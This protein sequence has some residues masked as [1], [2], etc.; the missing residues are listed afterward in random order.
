MYSVRMHFHDITITLAMA[1]HQEP[2]INLSIILIVHPE[3][4]W[5]LMLLKLLKNTNYVYT[6]RCYLQLF[7]PMVLFSSAHL[8]VL[9]KKLEISRFR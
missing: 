8:S 1:E 7:V 6:V 4:C 9:E 3:I 5:I 2:I